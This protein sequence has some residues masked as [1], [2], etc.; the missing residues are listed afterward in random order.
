MTDLHL[1]D[2]AATERFG[3][4]L[5]AAWIATGRAALLVTLDGDLGAGKTTLVRSLL[6][7]LGEE[8]AIRSPTYTLL[9]SYRPAPG[10]VVHH[11][12]CYRLAGWQ[13][14]EE[15]G[16]RDL[17]D[18]PALIAVEWPGRIPGL[19]ESADLGLELAVAGAGRRLAVTARSARGQAVSRRLDAEPGPT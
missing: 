8:G 10:T 2:E 14:L 11:L 3:R 7:A 18:E 4:R 12:D 6:R 16:F 19:Q 1:A 15:L 13:A 5:A 9:E 17:A